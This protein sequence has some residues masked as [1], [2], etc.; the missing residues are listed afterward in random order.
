MKFVS[1]LSCIA[2]GFPLFVAGPA[3]AGA[4]TIRAVTYNRDVAPIIFR[5]C[6][7]CHR[8]GE[9][10]PFNLLTYADARRR[11]RLIA[12]VTRNRTM[13]PW[14]PEPGYGEFASSR[15]LSDSD[16]S[17]IQQWVDQGAVKGAV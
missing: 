14:K 16:I 3:G 10:G 9:N 4:S 12:A 17:L 13:P 5:A 11:A 1:R 7:S 2:I 15:R 8:P 6:S